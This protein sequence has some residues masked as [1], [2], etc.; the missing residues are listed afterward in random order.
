M[1]IP[2]EILLLFFLISFFIYTMPFQL[3]KF[4]QTLHGKLTLLIITVLI[5]LY[6]RTGGLLMAMLIIFLEEFNYEGDILEGFFEKDANDEFRKK[7]CLNSSL[8]DAEGKPSK[9]TDFPNIIFTGQPCDPC[10]VTCKFTIKD[11]LEADE[12][13]KSKDAKDLKESKE[14]KDAK[15]LKESN[16]AKDTA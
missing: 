8:I 13:L 2:T 3:I 9:I 12:L 16:D 7:H 10:A 11:Q 6:N 4:S 15:D 14:S 5:T 1:H